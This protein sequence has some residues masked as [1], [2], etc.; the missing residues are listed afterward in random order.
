MSGD[1]SNFLSQPVV[2]NVLVYRN[3]DQFFEGRR[4]VVNEKRVSS[5]ESFLKEATG[6]V[7]APF[8]AVRNIYTPRAG[9]RVGALDDLQNGEQYVAAGREKFK[10]IDYLQI[11]TKKKK[12][13]QNNTL[14]IKPVAHSRIVVSARFLR[15]IQE[16][17]AI[18]VIAN[19]DILNPAV[20][21][22]IPRRIISQWELVLEMITEKMSLRILGAVRSLCTLDGNFVRDGKQ[23]ENGQFYVAV[24]REKFKKLPY[25]DLIFTKPA[26]IRRYNGSKTASLP[27]IFRFRKHKESVEDRQSKST[28]GSS[29]T[30]DPLASP[31]PP[32]MKG[33]KAQ[34]SAAN[35]AVYHGKPVKVKRNKNE[36]I[37]NIPSDNE[38]GVFKAYE[39]K[40]ETRGAVEVQEDEDLQV[41]LPV[42]QRQAETVDEEDDVEETLKDEEL[43]EDN[44]WESEVHGGQ[45]ADGSTEE[46]TVASWSDH[47]EDLINDNKEEPPQETPEEPPQET[48]EEP[49]QEMPEL[50]EEES[51][52]SCSPLGIETPSS[53]ESQITSSRRSES[54][55]KTDEYALV[56]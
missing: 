8:G 29:D 7:Q 3:G 42:D 52:K 12:P 19:G 43:V 14:Q 51:R 5:F 41:E 16:P 28:G 44:K 20:R 26:P 9:H 25:G 1:R 56:A 38:E 45:E 55:E 24:G 54:A 47:E 32:K 2:K 27:P 17:C 48:P 33:K 30:G 18:F 6:G 21:L 35:D 11:G 31:Q 15:P 22:L 53:P 46:D 50:E 36:I 4:L 10:K 13:A 40:L 39:E 37:S 34:F 49:Y 23:L